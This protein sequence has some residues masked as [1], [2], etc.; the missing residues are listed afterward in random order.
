MRTE[1]ETERDG[2]VGKRVGSKTARQG[3]R[4]GRR[5]RRTN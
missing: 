5:H 2:G 4:E 3:G 1:A